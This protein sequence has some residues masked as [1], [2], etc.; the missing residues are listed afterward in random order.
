MPSR[1]PDETHGE[2]IAFRKIFENLPELY[3]LLSSELII[4]AVSD[5]YLKETLAIRE[6]IVGKYIF[7]VF[8]DNPEVPDAHG[9]ANLKASL[10]TVLAT[11]KP[12]EMLVQHYDVQRP[13]ALGGGFET[14]YWLPLNTPVLNDKGE[15]LYII[16]QVTNV[17]EQVMARKRGEQNEALLQGLAD[18]SPVSLWM[19]DKNGAIIYV[20]QTWTDWTGRPFETH[21][22]NGWVLSILEEERERIAGKL[23]NDIY[24]RAPF[25]AEFRLLHVDGTIRWCLAEGVPHYLDDTFVG[26]VG[27]CNDITKRKQSE[28]ELQNMT[29]ELAEANKELLSVN[30]QLTHINLDLDNF[31]YAASHDLKA[32][33]ANIEGLLEILSDEISLVLED[34]TEVQQILDMMQGSVERFKKTIGN[35][36][37]VT[38]LQKEN[39]KEI[40]P[41]IVQEVVQEVLLDLEQLIQK[42][43]AQ[44]EIDVTKCETI[45]FSEKNLRSIV[46]NLISNAIKYSSPERSPLVQVAYHKEQ[47]YAVLTVQDNGSGMNEKQV[48]QLFTMFR[49]FHDHVEGSGVGLYMVKRMVENAGGRIEV[50]SVVGL[51][52]TFTVYLKNQNSQTTGTG[53]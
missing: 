43:N 31:I 19:T 36:T 32:P 22:G 35:L 14:R 34:R 11:R 37:D 24:A 13:A 17:T 53:C 40:T 5:A 4:L 7:E 26:Y 21:L 48:G 29:E 33:I 39:N 15:V 16:H 46:Y 25:Y 2:A 45:H 51:G 49:R 20:N 41:I 28:Q 52:T 12:H 50:N 44:V 3:L 18:T 47:G 23:L 38:K 27:S 10:Q 42:S 30:Q 8:P 1:S 6:H 9:V